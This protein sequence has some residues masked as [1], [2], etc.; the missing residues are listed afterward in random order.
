M[1]NASHTGS[2][3]HW[4]SCSEVLRTA[5]TFVRRLW[6]SCLGHMAW[7]VSLTPSTLRSLSVNACMERMDMESCT[8]PEHASAAILTHQSNAEHRAIRHFTCKEKFSGCG[9]ICTAAPVLSEFAK[10]ILQQQALPPPSNH[11]GNYSLIIHTKQAKW[12]YII[13]SRH[14]GLR[15]PTLV[16]NM[17]SL[18]TEDR[19]QDEGIIKEHWSGLMLVKVI[20]YSLFSKQKQLLKACIY[21]L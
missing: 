16:R 2:C 13:R 17:Q 8:K 10:G 18:Y 6:S 12:R 20:R 5:V 14:T 4:L 11:Q 15:S 9:M 21:S 19:L 1:Q 3:V 7:P